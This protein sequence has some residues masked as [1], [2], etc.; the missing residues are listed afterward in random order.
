MFELAAVGDARAPTLAGESHVPAGRHERF[1]P[2][3]ELRR[4]VAHVVAGLFQ[5]PEVPPGK[6]D[7]PR[8]R[9]LGHRR[10]GAGEQYPFAG[11][12]IEGGRFDPRRAVGAGV[13]API[14]GNRQEDVGRAL[15]SR[16][17]ARLSE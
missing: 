12:A 10:V 16:P 3:G 7:R 9:A 13:S 5:L 17:R 6:Q 15:R 11:H 4:E 2:G 14:V 8:R 1:G